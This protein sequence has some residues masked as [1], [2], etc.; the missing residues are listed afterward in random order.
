MGS[1]AATSLDVSIKHTVCCV[2]SDNIRSRLLIWILD[3][4]RLT[5]KDG[6]KRHWQHIKSESYR[7]YDKNILVF[8]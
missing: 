7:P 4:L 2:K 8:V 5:L 6:I 3:V 1:K